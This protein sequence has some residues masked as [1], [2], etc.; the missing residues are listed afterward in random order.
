M[1]SPTGYSKLLTS[2]VAGVALAASVGL[3]Q[4]AQALPI[5]IDSF[6]T[7]T[8]PNPLTVNSSS[9]DTV[10]Y[11]QTIS[12][13]LSVNPITRQSTLNAANA[14]SNQPSTLTIG[15]NLFTTEAG[16]GGNRT[17]NSTLLYTGFN[18][19]FNAAGASQFAFN[20]SQTGANSTDTTIRMSV[21]GN[22]SPTQTFANPVTS[23]PVT[24][25]FSDFTGSPS[26]FNNVSSL[27]IF[28]ATTNGNRA[29]LGPIRAAVPVP[30]AVLG[31]L[32]LAGIAA[33]KKRKQKLTA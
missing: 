19:N 20:F 31:T 30:P 2:S 17:A 25:L 10:S 13:D 6:T 16:S 24:F 14:I 21:N 15:S 28:V 29:S 27:Q 7:S 11:S 12:N 32:L 4:P 22:F 3:C 5:V 8:S 18:F 1:K 9:P 26:I 33:I 23:A